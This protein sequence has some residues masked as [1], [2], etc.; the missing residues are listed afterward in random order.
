MLTEI[1]NLKAQLA[2]KM[3]CVTS[4]SVKT[5]VLAPGMY[6]IDVEPIPP[7]HKNNRNAHLDYLNHLKESVETIREVLKEARIAKPL[8]NALES[9]YIYTKHS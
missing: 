8:D 2:G 4:E 3:K 7:S 6:A 9:S 1:K 5:K